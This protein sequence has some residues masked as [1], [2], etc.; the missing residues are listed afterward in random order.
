MKKLSDFIFALFVLAVLGTSPAYSY[1]D[2]AS[3][4]MALQIVIGAVAGGLIAIKLYLGKIKAFFGR[5]RK[6]SADRDGRPD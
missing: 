5:F 6:P 1:L 3:I 2:P 4:S